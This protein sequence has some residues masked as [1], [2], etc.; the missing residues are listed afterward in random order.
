MPL[1]SHV[2][3]SLVCNFKFQTLTYPLSQPVNFWSGYHQFLLNLRLTR[4][5]SLSSRVSNQGL[6]SINGQQFCHFDY[7]FVFSDVTLE[8]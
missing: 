2:T 7:H 4:N 6:V 5:L 1:V 8:K 3:F